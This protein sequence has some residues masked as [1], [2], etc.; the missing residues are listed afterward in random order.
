MDEPIEVCTTAVAFIAA[1]ALTPLANHEWP[2]RNSPQARFAPG[3]ASTTALSR[4]ARASM[5]EN[6]MAIFCI[7]GPDRPGVDAGSTASQDPR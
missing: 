2:A 4:S 7:H 1:R 3:G 5:A 6:L